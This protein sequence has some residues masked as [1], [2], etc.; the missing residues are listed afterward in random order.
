MYTRILRVRDDTTTSLMNVEERLNSELSLKIIEVQNSIVGLLRKGELDKLVSHN[1]CQLQEDLQKRVA[2]LESQAEVTS[3][4]CRS[5]MTMCE[6]VRLKFA[7][8]VK[9]LEDSMKTL[10]E[11]R[12]SEPGGRLG[13]VRLHE[14]ME[15]LEIACSQQ[16]KEITQIKEH[17][18]ELS[19]FDERMI[20]AE[21]A[22]R[23][24]ARACATNINI[25]AFHKEI[26]ALEE[27]IASQTA[28]HHSDT[29]AALCEEVASLT[30]RMPTAER[31]SRQALEIPE[32]IDAL[33]EVKRDIAMRVGPLKTCSEDPPSNSAECSNKGRS[34]LEELDA[35]T[36]RVA[37]TETVVSFARNELNT[38]RDALLAPSQNGNHVTFDR[39]GE[40]TGHDAQNPCQ[41]IPNLP[42]FNHE[43]LLCLP[44]THGHDVTLPSVD[45]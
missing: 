35:L 31:L 3:S 42:S 12:Q 29:L 7:T 40:L 5:A 36:A 30:L 34:V 41:N 16:E 39:V 9:H 38:I 22:I 24:L 43:T 23:E 45:T 10:V 6:D 28:D 11:D 4:T 25:G 2:E 33:Q 8:C 27:R 18:Q 21:E 44:V 37:Q 15:A 17:H 1:S 32:F 20:S 14:R 26:T 13:I 19:S